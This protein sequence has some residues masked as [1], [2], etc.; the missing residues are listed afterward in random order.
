MVMEYGK[1]T[2]VIVIL[3]NGGI[4]KQRAMVFIHGK[5]EINMKVNGNSA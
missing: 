2:K 3:E 1:E 5:T 4:L